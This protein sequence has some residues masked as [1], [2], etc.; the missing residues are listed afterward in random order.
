MFLGEKE[1]V[2]SP[3]LIKHYTTF[4]CNPLLFHLSYNCSKKSLGGKIM[5]LSVSMIFEQKPEGWGLR[6]DPYLWDELQ[7]A[8]GTIPLPCSKTCFIHH[9][10]KFFYELTNHSLRSESDFWVEKYDYG[11]MSGGGISVEFW[12]KNALPLLITRLQKFSKE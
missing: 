5:K 3:P 12:K 1:V 6:G 2:G 9:F 10:E 11:G 4:K 7:Q 8:F